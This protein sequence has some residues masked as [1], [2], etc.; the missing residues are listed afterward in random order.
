MLR[1]ACVVSSVFF[2]VALSLAAQD[3]RH[4]TFSYAF[5]IKKSFRR[6]KSSSVDPGGPVDAYQ[7][8]KIISAKG[9]L[10][11]KKTSEFEVQRSDLLCRDQLRSG[12]AALRYRI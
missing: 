9:D 10:P 6:R 2:V 11:L 1:K 8:V 3:S 12:G 7:D 4:F 5:T